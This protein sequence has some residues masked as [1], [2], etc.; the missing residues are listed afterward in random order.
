MEY[1]NQNRLKKLIIKTV[2]KHTRTDVNESEPGT[3]IDDSIGVDAAALYRI[4]V[5]IDA[6]LELGSSDGDWSFDGSIQG[7][8]DY[9]D[10]VLKNRD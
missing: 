10:R 9:Y 8:V 4:L 7:L 5:D 1:M 2:S 6:Q 3:G